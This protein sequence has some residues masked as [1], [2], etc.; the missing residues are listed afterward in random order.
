MKSYDWDFATVWQYKGVLLS[1]GLVTLKLI[2]LTMLV[3]IIVGFVLANVRMTRRRV[4]AM[5]AMALI[6]F[7][8]AV[9]PL[10]LLIWVYYCIPILVDVRLSAFQTGVLALGLYSA[11]FYAEIFRAGIQS[12]E[13]GQIEAGL[14]VGMT[15]PQ[16]L[17][18]ITLPVAFMRVFPPFVSQSAL[19]IKNTVLVSAIAVGELLYEGQRLSIHTF[20]PLEILTVVALMFI[21][22]IMPLTLSANALEARIR[23]RYR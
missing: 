20:R 5:V 6:E 18:R 3:G 15:A 2:L 8:R 16:V 19:V 13:R 14:A 22:I 7:L 11:A 12:I 10:V 1:A 21:A 23:A 17:R 9:P 4:L